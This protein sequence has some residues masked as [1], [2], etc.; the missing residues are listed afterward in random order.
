MIQKKEN[1]STHILITTKLKAKFWPVQKLSS[2]GLP[3]W[4][5]LFTQRIELALP[6]FIQFPSWHRATTP[7]PCW[8]VIYL[9]VFLP[10]ETVGYLGENCASLIFLSLQLPMRR[11]GLSRCCTG[12]QPLRLSQLSWFSTGSQ[13][14]IPSRIKNSNFQD[15]H[16]TIKSEIVGWGAGAITF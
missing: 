9:H 3:P 4:P 15:A 5:P 11:L 16:Q 13:P 6:S 12:P 2:P 14:W 10:H 1:K 8:A 7:R